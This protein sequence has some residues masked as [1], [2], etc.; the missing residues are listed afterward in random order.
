[1]RVFEKPYRFALF[2]LQI[3][4]DVVDGRVAHVWFVGCR[5]ARSAHSLPALASLRLFYFQIDP[6]FVLHSDDAKDGTD[7]L[8]RL[9]RAADDLAHVVLM[10][11]KREKYAHLIYRAIYLDVVGVINQRFHHVFQELLISFHTLL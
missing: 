9:A 3:L 5:R 11:A 4:D 8:G 2:T 7:G 1:M 10:N 6:S